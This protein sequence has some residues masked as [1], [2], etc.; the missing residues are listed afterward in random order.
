MHRATIR[1]PQN[2]LALLVGEIAA[3]LQ[4]AFD[5]IDAPFAAVAML[6]VFGVNF[7]VLQAHADAGEIELLAG[8]I[9][10]YGHRR[11]G[12]QCCQ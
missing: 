4:A 12:S 8:G 10:A 7:I 1:N 5:A 6:T 3:Q 11:T 2:I 9:H